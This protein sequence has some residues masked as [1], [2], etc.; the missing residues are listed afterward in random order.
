MTCNL[1]HQPMT[2]R[3][4]WSQHVGEGVYV[5]RVTWHCTAKRVTAR[6]I[7]NTCANVPHRII[8]EPPPWLTPEERA[9]YRGLAEREA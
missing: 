2:I 1:C 9:K 4:R 8:I 5:P 3:R 6:L 7:D